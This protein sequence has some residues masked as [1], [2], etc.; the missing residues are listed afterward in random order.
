MEWSSPTVLSYPNLAHDHLNDV[1]AYSNTVPVHQ[2]AI[3]VSPNAFPD[4]FSFYLMCSSSLLS[5]ASLSVVIPTVTIYSNSLGAGHVFSGLVV[6]MY[7]ISSALF[8]IPMTALLRKTAF[9]SVMI[10]SC[11][12]GIVGHALYAMAGL[13]NLPILLLLSRLVLGSG[14]AMNFVR[15]YIAATVGSEHR[16]R[17]FLIYKTTQLAGYGLG[18]LIGGMLYDV[19]FQIGDLV[20]DSSTS[21]AWFMAIVYTIATLLFVFRFEEPSAAYKAY[22]ELRLSRTKGT[23]WQQLKS[24]Y[25]TLLADRSFQVYCLGVQTIASTA[26]SMWEVSIQYISSTYWGFSVV[27]TG[28]LMSACIGSGVISTLIYVVCNKKKYISDGQAFFFTVLLAAVFS[29]LLFDYQSVVVFCLGSAGYMMLSIVIMSIGLSFLTTYTP[30]QHA[31]AMIMAA[32][33]S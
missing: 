3:P 25:K 17:A 20:I 11:L 28:L 4:Q 9:K 26:N 8:L 5:F 19:N 21:P 29:T 27:V 15:L 1:N 14:V 32:V 16:T 2:K 30:P 6:G 7:A 22:E 13:A 18:P 24:F 33:C 12:T 23:S 10:L 31:D